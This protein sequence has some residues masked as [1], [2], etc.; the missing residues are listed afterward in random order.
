MYC[1]TCG[2]ELPDDATFCTNCGAKVGATGP[3][4]VSPPP[5][6]YGQPYGAPY[7][8]VP[9]KSEIIAIILGFF[10]PGAGHLYIGKIVRGI[11]YLVT[12]FGLNII[13]FAL[14]WDEVTRLMETT[15]PTAIPDLTGGSWA[16]VSIIGLVTFVIWIVN[17]IDVYLLTKKYNDELR[18][19]GKAPW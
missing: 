1:Q 11:I 9:L 10:F 2:T 14:I 16:L 15:D 3:T 8:Q 4:P 13:S 6:Y 7:S 19:T 18:R 12:Y 17:L 5:P